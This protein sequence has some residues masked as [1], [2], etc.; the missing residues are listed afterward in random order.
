MTMAGLET[1]IPKRCYSVTG[2]Q[3]RTRSRLL[4]ETTVMV[5]ITVTD[6]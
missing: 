5:T 4:D 6:V 1:S 2:R 3:P